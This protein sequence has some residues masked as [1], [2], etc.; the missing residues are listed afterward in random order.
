LKKQK[1]PG[2]FQVLFLLPI[3]RRRVN[4]AGFTLPAFFSKG[5]QPSH[6]S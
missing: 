1:A 3:G 6:N 4:E 2:L 5:M